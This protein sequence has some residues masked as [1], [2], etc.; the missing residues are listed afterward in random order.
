MSTRRQFLVAS[1]SLLL[2]APLA[3]AAGRA[4]LRFAADPFSLGVASG[5]P[6]P[7]SMVL[8]TRLAPQPLAPG[9]GMD[10]V[11]VPVQWELA[12]DERFAKVVRSGI[13]W[14]E[15][16][17]G[18]S[19]HV[20]PEGLEAGRDYWYRFRVG[21]TVSP[22]GRTWTATPAGQSRNSLQIAVACCQHWETGFYT[23]YQQILRDAPDMILHVGDYIY[24]NNR[25]RNRVRDH[26]TAECYTLEDYRARY[27]LYR[28][29]AGLRAAHAACPW[30]LVPDDHEVDNDYANDISEDDDVP[31]LFL[32]RRALAYQAYYEN[33]PLPRRAVPMGPDIRL[34]SSRALG[35][36]ASIHLLD[37]RQY[38]SPHAC[39]APGR[40]GGNR[41]NVDDCPQL[42]DSSRTMLG[43]Q[44][45]VWIDA[46]LASDKARWNLVVQGVVTAYVQEEPGSKLRYWTDSW[47]GYAPARQR[48]MDSI[49]NRAP[50][51]PL[52]I[53][54]DIHAFIA[55]DIRRRPGDNS[56]PLLTSELVATSVSSEG[57][58][59][60]VMD[61]T[62]GGRP[63]VHYADD[64][65]RGYLRLQLDAKQ[66]RADMVAMD[67]VRE[68]TSKAS[69]AASFVLEAGRR[70]LQSA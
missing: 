70:G 42:L 23:A 21:N 59:K 54:G 58:G 20:E 7:D 53:G 67:S 29:D 69:V 46:R 14:A 34:Y 11:V 3:R 12:A 33:Q 18:H 47:N 52:I 26:G 36:L 41:V 43:A 60:A 2:A 51:N 16:A 61:A 13:T 50:P 55:S 68:P 56:T 39:P 30:M 44:Q 32:A 48:L 5:F 27:A 4:P 10:P 24:E 57:A 37:E 45:E 15:P 22:V 25:A 35:D 38:R 17:L 64:A 6:S 66:V 65:K 1:S 40:R 49:S 19:V 9:G 28:S 62:L 63:E 8:W 31:A